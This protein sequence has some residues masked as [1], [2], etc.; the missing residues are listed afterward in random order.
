M[1]QSSDVLPART[2]RIFI[3]LF[4]WR[5]FAVDGVAPATF[6]IEID[7]AMQ[8]PTIV[9]DSSD[10]NIPEFVQQFEYDLDDDPAS[11]LAELTSN[12]NCRVDF[13]CIALGNV[14]ALELASAW[15]K[16][17]KLAGASFVTLAVLGCPETARTSGRGEWHIALFANSAASL[18]HLLHIA[19]GARPLIGYDMADVMPHWRGRT[20]WVQRSNADLGELNAILSEVQA[21][22]GRR[23]DALTLLLTYHPQQGGSRL[24]DADRITEGLDRAASDANTF[25]IMNEPFLG[26][27]PDGVELA[28]MFEM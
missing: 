13:I 28:V 12:F 11:A 3:N 16:A 9:D 4:L 20:G 26:D 6:A 22:F 14:D 23:A 8:K 27:E 15:T 10:R 17:G 25:L 1:N 5:W 24:L 21:R 7:V 19:L 2:G 18:N